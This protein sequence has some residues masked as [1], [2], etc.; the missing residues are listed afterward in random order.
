MTAIA[1]GG[2]AVWIYLVAGRYGTPFV[3]AKKVGLGGV[4][5]LLGRFVVVA[6]HEIAHGLTVSSFFRRECPRG[7]APPQ[8]SRG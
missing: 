5:F 1:V 6:V 3:V 4:V 8:C 2:A 7:T